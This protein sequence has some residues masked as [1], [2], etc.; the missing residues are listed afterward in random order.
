MTSPEELRKL[1]QHS[2]DRTPEQTLGEVAQG[3]LVSGMIA[4]G[5]VWSVLLVAGTALP[6]A[7]AQMNPPAEKAADAEDEATSDAS[8]EPAPAE[9]DVADEPSAD[10]KSSL[11]EKLGHE[12]ADPGDPN[13]NPLDSKVDDLLN[14]LK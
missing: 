4:S 5:V 11:P 3:S 14:D 9:D 10:D 1:L 12:T 8:D 6:Y 2:Q 13:V 7:W